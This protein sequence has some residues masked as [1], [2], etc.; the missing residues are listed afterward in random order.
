MKKFISVFLSLIIA[1]QLF[2][3]SARGAD[4]CDLSTECA[5]L[6]CVQTGELLLEKN[7]H[8]RHSMASTTK[9]MT[10]L[11]ALEQK[12]PSRIITAD[13]A[14]VNVE[15]TSMGLKAGDKVSLLALAYGMLLLSGNDGAN[16]TAKALGGSNEGFAKIMNDRAKE[17]GMKNTHFVT[18]SGLDDDGHYTTA[19]DMALLGCAAVKNPDFL[20]ICSKKKASVSY[21]NPPCEITI[22]N[23][24]RLLSSYDGALGIKTGFTKKSGRCLVSCAERD[25]VML[26]AVTLNAPDDWADHRKML[27]YGFSSI[28]KCEMQESSIAVPVSGGVKKSVAVSGGKITVC[29][30]NITK[31]IYTE[32][33]LY[34]P[35]KKG[36]IAGEVRYFSGGK[37]IAKA[38][39]TVDSSVA[40]LPVQKESEEKGFFRKLKDIFRRK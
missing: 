23:H 28:S 32:K 26:V 15:G 33:F 27:D 17:L 36:E 18:P 10:A 37:L 30:E 34:A 14:S 6:M 8:K 25:G 31:R 20:S 3:L 16:L 9:I 24:N 13:S 21:G 22:Y 19:Y 38:P 1:L 29:A 5:A 11:L 40:A 7:A 12:T 4:G 39:L 2:A 35:V